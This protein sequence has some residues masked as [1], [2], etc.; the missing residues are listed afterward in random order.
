VHSKRGLAIT[1][2]RVT[3]QTAVQL[4]GFAAATPSP[5]PHFSVDG[6]R[7]G[8]IDWPT[9]LSTSEG[10]VPIAFEHRFA[11]PG[12]HLVSVDLDPLPGTDCLPADNQQ[13]L[14]VE[15]R[16][17]LPLLLVDGERELSPESSTFFLQRAL[18]ADQADSVRALPYPELTPR[19]LAD[20][21]VVVLADVPHLTSAQIDALDGYVAQG[22]SLLVILGERM[23]NEAA[24]YNERLYRRGHGWL[25]AELRGVAEST[26][27]PAQPEVKT[28]THP[29][30]ELLAQHSQALSQARF[31]HWWKLT[32]GTDSKAS[33]MGLLSTGDPLFVEKPY[34]QGRVILCTVPLDRRWGSTL[35]GMWEYPVLVHELISYLAGSR[36]EGHRLG[37]GVPIRF[38]PHPPIALPASLSLDTPGRDRQQFS[39][40]TWPWLYADTGAIG[41]YR[42]E[43]GNQV[44]W[45][46]RAPDLRESELTACS[47]SDWQK[48]RE[49]L[50]FKIHTDESELAALARPRQDLWWLLLLGVILLLCGEVWLTRRLLIAR[51]ALSS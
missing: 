48:L 44:D 49:I 14:V 46:T 1:G 50:P 35:P 47:A 20:A 29:A 19:A 11:A 7:I 39:S 30:L 45:F 13:H 3:F 40:S 8:A 26:D 28:F 27:S 25:P 10:R 21:S 6:K 31:S 33:A 2:E 4:T 16:D 41:A 36:A 23:A 5:R 12:A 22:G 51:G 9:S 37:S 17:Q 42:V 24:F 34:Q 43:T 18:K 38:E 32:T 15:V